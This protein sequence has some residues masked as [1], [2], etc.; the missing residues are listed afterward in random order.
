M[1][2]ATMK[3]MIKR[4]PMRKHVGEVMHKGILSCDRD[5]SLREVAQTMS[6]KRVHCVVVESGSDRFELKLHF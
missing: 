6:E 3:T 4:D 5:A 2:G 1:R